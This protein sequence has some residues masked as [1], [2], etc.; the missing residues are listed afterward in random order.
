MA[1]STVLIVLAVLAQFLI[2]LQLHSVAD[3]RGKCKLHRYREIYDPTSF[4]LIIYQL[5][6]Q[7]YFT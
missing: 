2:Y 3:A 1:S 7:G 5:I 6:I 4:L